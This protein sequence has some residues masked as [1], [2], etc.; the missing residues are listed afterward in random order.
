VG[1][2]PR[3]KGGKAYIFEVVDNFSKLLLKAMKKATTAAVIKFLTKEL[4]NTFG[5]PE[6][7]HSDN[8]KQFVA[9]KFVEMT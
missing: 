2:Y 5:V 4:F 7:I 1:K 3:P 6:I 8:G 9:K